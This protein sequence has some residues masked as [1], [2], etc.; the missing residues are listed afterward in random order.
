MIRRRDILKGAT[1][2]ALVSTLPA[3]LG[4]SRSPDVEVPEATDPV[5]GHGVA[6][7]DPLADA[8]ILWTRVTTNEAAS[9]RW[10]IAKD[11]AFADVAAVG[12][13]TAN[14]ERD[15]TVKVD[16]TGLEPGT[17]YYYRFTALG[18]T[19]PIGRTRTAPSH[20]KRLRFSVVS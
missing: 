15:Y 10:E 13:A 11:M 12:T 3:G 9:V 1:S 4:C 20:T 17:T 8:V 7:G 6:S 5:F 16:V 2:L 14:A 19:S 18:L